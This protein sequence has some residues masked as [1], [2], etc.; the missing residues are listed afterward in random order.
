MVTARPLGSCAS[1]I[2]SFGDEIFLNIQPELTAK[3]FLAGTNLHLKSVLCCSSVLL[4][5]I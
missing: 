5:L 2:C 4:R 1:A 3:P